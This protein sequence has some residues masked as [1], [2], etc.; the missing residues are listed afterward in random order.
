MERVDRV[1]IRYTHPN[2]YRSTMTL[3]VMSVG[4]AVNLWRS[5]PTF[6]P[7]DIDKTLV[8]LIFCLLGV[9]QLLVLNLGYLR[10]VRIGMALSS[11]TMVS[12]G[13]A[14][15]E[16]AFAGA[17]S[18]QLP[19]LYFALGVVQFLLLIEPPVNPVAA[20]QP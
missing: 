8:A 19:I 2:L 4:L 7:Y 13:W 14:N 17:A 11:F 12:W 9:S 6:N 16:Q 3:S 20:R 15:T 1:K 5:N 10:V 18:F